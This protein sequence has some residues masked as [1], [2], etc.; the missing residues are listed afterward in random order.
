M[1]SS[2]FVGRESLEQVRNL[3][4]LKLSRI[5]EGDP[6]QGSLQW[7]PEL[8]VSYKQSRLPIEGFGHE[9]SLKTSI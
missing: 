3:G 6:I 9:L 2:G 8:S 7:E 5:Y 4:Q 1:Q